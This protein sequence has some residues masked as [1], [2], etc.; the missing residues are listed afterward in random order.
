[1][2]ARIITSAALFRLI[3][4]TLVLISYPKSGAAAHAFKAPL[5]LQSVYHRFGIRSA[6][7]YSVNESKVPHVRGGELEEQT[8]A[9][10]EEVLDDGVDIGVEADVESD[11]GIDASNE[12]EG[13]EDDLEVPSLNHTVNTINDQQNDVS[14]GN[15]QY[16]SEYD[17]EEEALNQDNDVIDGYDDD[18]AT[19][20]PNIGVQ[21]MTQE[22]EFNANDG[23]TTDANS[24]TEINVDEGGD[25]ERY[26]RQLYTLGARAHSLVRKS[27]ILVDGPPRSGL[28]YETIKNLALSGVGRVILLSN[29]SNNTQG[30]VEEDYFNEGMDDLGLTYRRGAMA[31]C[32]PSQD[33]AEIDSFNLIIEYVRRLNPSVKIAVMS[34]SEFVACTKT[35]QDC[36]DIDS[37]RDIGNNP[38]LMCIDRPLSTQ[39]LLNEACRN[40]ADSIGCMRKGC[41]PFIAIETV[42]VFGKA[43]CDFGDN[44]IVVDEDGETP[45]ATLLDQI[46]YIEDGKV[47][48]HCV[49]GERHDVS[50]GDQIA[51]QWKN[52]VED[53]SVMDNIKCVV[54]YVKNPTCFS[55]KFGSSLKNGTTCEGSEFDDLMRNINRD[56][57]AFQ[58]VKV[59]KS[60]SFLS[61]RDALE[62]QND[63]KKEIFAASDL[64]KSFDP[65]RRSAVMA[66]FA[67]LETIVNDQRQ[68][69]A[70]QNADLFV[71]STFESGGEE[72]THRMA[73]ISSFARCAKAKFTPLQAIYGAVGAQEA[74]KAASGLYN[75]VKQFLLYD[76]DE[77]L[78]R[79]KHQN[80]NEIGAKISGITYIL[81]K[82][83]SKKLSSQKVFVVGSGAIGCE[84]LKN[85]AAMNVGT[86]KKKGGCV[87]LTDM[88]TIEKSNLSRQLLFRDGD[89]GKF[90]STAAKEAMQRLNPKVN[91][92]VHTCKVGDDAKGTYFDDKFWSN[93]VDVVLNA[94]D[95]VEARLFIDSQ[96]VANQKALVDAGTLGAKGNVQVIVPCQSESYASSSDP[97]EPTIAVCTLKNFPYEISHTIQWG[98]DLFDGLFTRRPGQVN[99]HKQS[100]F[101]T[102]PSEFAKSLLDKLGEDASMLVANELAEDCIVFDRKDE[103]DTQQIKVSSLMWACDL[104]CSLFYDSMND[105]L[106]QHPLNSLDDDDNPFWSGARKAPTPLM[107]TPDGDSKVDIVNSNI[108]N[109]VRHA[110]RL[111]MEIYD[112]V[113]TESSFISEEEV[114]VSLLEYSE[115]NHSNVENEDTDSFQVRIT[116]K[117]ETAKLISSSM[118]EDLAIAEFEKDDDSNGHVDFVTA[119]SNLRAIVYGITPV[120][121]MET[122]RV[123]GRI[124]PAMISTTAF[125][126]AL[127]CIE[128]VKLVQKVKLKSHR[129]A[130]I[131]LALPFFAFTQPLPAEEIEGLHGSSYTIWDRVS[132]IEKQK[133][134]SNGGITMRR[135]LSKI[136]KKAKCG[137]D[138]I[139]VSSVSF[140]PFMLY[141]NFLHEDDVDVLDTPVKQLL[142][143]AVC[144]GDIEDDGYDD[145]GNYEE[146][147]CLS[148]AQ[149]VEVEAVRSQS[150]ADFTVLVEDPQTGEEAELP[151]VRILWFKDERMN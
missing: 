61:L 109:F 120:D 69:P 15:Y 70:F 142:M 63:P 50:K 67:A 22:V 144:S 23:D 86:M 42:G 139:E 83:L 41:L 101:T 40:L 24:V 56:S 29:N 125:V 92:N 81:G 13:E 111:R 37:A 97:P 131:N 90:K 76:C 88:D 30:R 17:D 110:A 93:G 99:E 27:T 45:K 132:I 72:S 126:S 115:N 150:F 130:F 3:F 65:T 14:D 103:N 28:V 36:G 51:F 135:F 55:A 112:Q 39:I 58:R 59:P 48:V 79:A 73:I 74:L 117:I 71:K 10:E 8:D 34:R 53:N 143:D 32:F 78:P 6:Q 49:E 7:G 57:K 94:L 31:E 151:P 148:E 44:F 16:E 116:E 43:F 119:A 26:S 75:P 96:C 80:A 68:L 141:A 138:E 87:T 136:K 9:Q 118:C 11:I 128:L 91:M 95:N 105:L 21:V 140:G 137:E 82:K 12:E 133:S 102:N 121:T 5:V 124:V 4:V 64:D 2:K 113:I 62:A 25:E 85:L 89:V 20:A 77:I 19:T 127:S 108:V 114:K 1:M 46:E 149:L 66:S 100:L 147:E 107:Y 146:E 33:E 47:D 106:K 98:R 122:R 38:V 18:T 35:N 134:F 84:V 52:E 60:L 123:A 54:D 145:N 129:N 104:A